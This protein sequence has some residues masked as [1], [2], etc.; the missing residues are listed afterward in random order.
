MGKVIDI[1]TRPNV[2][3]GST[4]LQVAPQKRSEKASLALAGSLMSFGP[5][6]VRS[7]DWP[8]PRRARAAAVA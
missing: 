5:A 2:S 3:L 8:T 7:A 4:S 6:A 1:T